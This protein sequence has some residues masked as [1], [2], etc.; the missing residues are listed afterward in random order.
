MIVE[1]RCNV[2]T[3]PPGKVGEIRNGAIKIAD[4]PPSTYLDKELVDK[5]MARYNLEG[6]PLTADEVENLK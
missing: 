3:A 4:I 6:R 2:T 1:I 5:I